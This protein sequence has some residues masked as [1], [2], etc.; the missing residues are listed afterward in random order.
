M[1]KRLGAVERLFP[2]PCALVV[3]GTLDDADTLAV[4]WINVVSSTPPTVA[5]GLRES[6]HTLAHIR[7]TGSFTVNIPTARMAAQL[8]YCGMASGAK[9]DKF[10]ATGLTLEPSSVVETPLIAE[11]PFNLECTVTQQVTVGS[12]VVVM[13][14]IVEAHA[15]IDVLRD[16]DGDIVDMAALDPLVYI[17]G[18]REYHRLGG[19]VADAYSAG[20]IFMAE[21]TPAE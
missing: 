7:R 2:M 13:G 17:A 11:C 16:P 14:E 19:K 6:R 21:E 12:Y 20:R 15:E 10:A 5:M 4:A 9:T 1:K 18:A 3:G 8:D